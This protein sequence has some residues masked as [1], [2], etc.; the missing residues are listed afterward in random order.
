MEEI[1]YSL[2]GIQHTNATSS[3][4]HL[5][6]RKQKCRNTDAIENTFL[7]CRNVAR[8]CNSVHMWPKGKSV[9][10]IR[11]FTMYKVAWR[12][13][14]TPSPRW[15][16]T[17]LGSVMKWSLV[18][19]DLLYHT[20]TVTLILQMLKYMLKFSTMNSPTTRMKQVKHACKGWQKWKPCLFSITT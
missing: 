4:H 19:H 5:Q 14:E 13:L 9:S 17:V 18:L 16:L 1:H 6:R 3:A 12:H 2:Y 8:W 11:I 20:L 7:I 10:I 15:L